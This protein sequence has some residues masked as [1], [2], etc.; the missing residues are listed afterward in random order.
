MRSRSHHRFN[1]RPRAQ[2]TPWHLE[3]LTTKAY[4]APRELQLIQ[5]PRAEPAAAADSLRSAA[6]AAEPQAV[7]RLRVLFSRPAGGTSGNR[8]VPGVIPVVGARGRRKFPPALKIC[9]PPNIAL[10]PT[11]P[12]SPSPRLSAK[13]LG[14][15]LFEP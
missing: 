3:G 8:Q 12:A 10:Q 13:P 2:R 15:M 5:Q 11:S 4:R 1:G 7:R 14:G 6:L 9:A